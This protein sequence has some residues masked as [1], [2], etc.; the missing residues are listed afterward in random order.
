M[1][2]ALLV[3]A[4]FNG[5]WQGALVCGTALLLFRCIRTVNASTMFTVWSVLLGICLALPV[6]NYVFAARPY[7]AMQTAAPVAAPAAHA[8]ASKDPARVRDAVTIRSSSPGAGGAFVPSLRDR[9]IGVV[10]AV[11]SHSVML[12]AALA[13]IALV[14]VTLLVRDVA[15]M[16]LARRAS[17]RIDP[18]VRAALRIG[19]PYAFASSSI[20]RSPCV[21]GFAPALIVIPDDLLDAPHERLLGVV[22]HEAEHVRRY[23]DVQNVLHRVISA[24]AFFCPGVHVAL[25]E[26]ALYR[27]QICDD[28]AI[29]RLGDP[30]AYAMTLT[31]MAGWAQ[32]RGVPVPSFIFK[33]KQLVRRLEMLLDRA[34]NHSLKIDRRAAFSAAAAVVLTAAIVLRFQVPVIAQQIVSPA[35]VVAARPA[36]AHAP[37]ARA[38]VAPAARPAP[39]PAAVSKMVPVAKAARAARP[40]AIARA[41]HFRAHLALRTVTRVSMQQTETTEA[42]VARAAVAAARSASSASASASASSAS[43]AAVAAYAPAAPGHSEGADSMLAALEQAGLRNLSVDQL[44]KLRDNGVQPNLITTAHSYFGN[45]LDVEALVHLS[46]NGIVASYLQSLSAAGFPHLAPA[47]VVRLYDNGVTGAYIARIRAYNSRASVDDIIRLHNSGF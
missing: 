12:L 41:V 17:K 38:A 39:A 28:A 45:A 10:S 44:I 47:D 29:G 2:L 9:V 18:P 8:A 7:V 46:Q 11:L 40:V 34:V 5:A 42:P 20:L 3:I 23:D 27:E 4:L 6:A 32:G 15:G 19:R 1:N 26:L 21:L 25:R 16:V 22:L 14:R 33:R 43:G 24:L 36:I 13:L 35:P 37:P 31:S 30:V